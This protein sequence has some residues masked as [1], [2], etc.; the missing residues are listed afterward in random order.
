MNS[1]LLIPLVLYLVAVF[2]VALYA[3]RKRDTGNGFLT[4]Y[5][6]GNRSM[7]GFVLAMTLASTYASASS[8]IGGPGAAYKMGLGWV[9]LAM[10][11]LPA[12]WLTLGVLGKKFAI[13]ARRHNALT[14]N[15]IL[16][17]RYKNRGVV[18]FA[19]LALLLAFFGTMVVQFV[20]G[21]RLLQTVTGLSYQHGLM[22]FAVTVGLYTTIGGFRAVVMTDTVQGIMMIIGTIA[23]LVG[24]VHAGGSVGEMIHTLH[25]IDP[26]LIS[27]YGPDQF[28]SQP[29]M[30]SF[31]VLVC[32]GVIGLPHAAVRCMSYKSSGSLHKG[33]VI[34]TAMVALLMLGMHL[35]GA[36]GRALVPDI[37]SPDQIMP[38]LMMTVL[39]PVVAGVFLAG[40]MAAIMS[41]IDSQLIQASAT[42]LKDLYLN[43]INPQALTAP[44]AEKRLP[45]L[46]LWVTGIFSLLVFI[47]A[48]N[49][50]DMIIWL[51]LLA[52]GGMQAVF[53]WPLVLGL[54]WKRASAT[55][56][57]ASM[58]CGLVCYI[59]LSVIKPDMGGIHAIIPTLLVGLIAFVVGSL[60]KP[61]PIQTPQQA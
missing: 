39:P 29:F 35:A 25:D 40:P 11:Q 36:L 17:A 16:Y 15:D 54:Y 50:P 38:T 49:P 32:F 4:E 48:T 21:A 12:A 56:A 14:L 27:P 28:L 57:F 19:S 60:V 22:L 5:L 51:N 18:I 10:I 13:E 37:A 6:V 53:L 52:F 8:F 46:S 33:M 2:A 47:A 45:K 26:A 41:T 61:V 30:L 44:D 59:G 43:Y 1:Q 9:L 31:W 58:I 34:S 24:I 55:G 20:G 3:N 42:L 7:G 23:L